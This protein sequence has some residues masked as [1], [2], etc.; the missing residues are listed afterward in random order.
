M[1]SCD[2]SNVCVNQNGWMGKTS[3]LKEFGF[4]K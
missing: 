4:F 1:V 3:N 2:M